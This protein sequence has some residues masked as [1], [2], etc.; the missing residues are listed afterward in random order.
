MKK[1]LLQQP[2]AYTSPL[3]TLANCE[4]E[5]GIAVSGSNWGGDFSTA[6]DTLIDIDETFWE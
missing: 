6:E 2:K 4:V 5:Q 3:L 1:E